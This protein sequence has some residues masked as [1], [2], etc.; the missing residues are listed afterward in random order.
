MTGTRAL[1]YHCD[2][3]GDL[4]S[5]IKAANGAETQ[6]LLEIIRNDATFDEVRSY[7]DRARAIIM[8]PKSQHEYAAESSRAPY[9]PKVMDLHYLCEFA[10]F[11]VPA[12]PWTTVTHDDGLVSH[13][14]SLFFAWDYPFYAFIDCDIFLKHMAMGDPYSDFCSPFLVNAL[15]A[16]ACVRSRDDLNY[17]TPTNT[18]QHYS[19]Y[20]EAYTVPGDIKTKGTDFLAEAER[21][22]EHCRYQKGS[23]V[24]LAS[25]Q[26]T[27]ILY[28]R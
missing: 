2:L 24:R 6:G 13:L 23:V 27:I 15:L 17:C 3:L 14:V 19:Q 26:A 4:F 25:L 12:Q 21:Y 22:L 28:E 10:P 5:F 7:L 9:R 8:Q 16:H 18:K 20:Q 1:D 11:R